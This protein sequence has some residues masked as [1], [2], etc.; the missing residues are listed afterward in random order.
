[1]GNAINY[2]KLAIANTKK[3]SNLA[4][5]FYHL[6]PCTIDEH[7]KAKSYICDKI[8]QFIQ[9]RIAIA[10]EIIIKHGVSKIT[11][12]DVILTYSRY[13]SNVFSP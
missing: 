7:I 12:G 11:N 13:T 5:V 1:M 6:S 9:E 2:L 3:M 4:E 8:D 10:D